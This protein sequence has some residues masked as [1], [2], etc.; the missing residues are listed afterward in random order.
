M[1]LRKQ[2]GTVLAGEVNVWMETGTKSG[3]WA[4]GKVYCPILEV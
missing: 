3:L 4:V 1:K 2:G